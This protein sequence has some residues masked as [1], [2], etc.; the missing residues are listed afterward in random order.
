MVV[1]ADIYGIP[2]FPDS[3]KTVKGVVGLKL[4][5]SF[6]ALGGAKLDFNIKYANKPGTDSLMPEITV[7]PRIPEQYKN[8][9]RQH[10]A[11]KTELLFGIFDGKELIKEL[12]LE[13]T[14]LQ[15]VDTSSF[16]FS[17]APKFPKGKYTGRLSIES[18]GY[19]PTHNSSK[20]ELIFK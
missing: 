4:D 20:I 5:T 19:L 12:R 14:A 9:I 16:A 7:I 6:A 10:P 13:I 8:F 3:V 1:V 15:L 2:T 11:L 18:N 17:M